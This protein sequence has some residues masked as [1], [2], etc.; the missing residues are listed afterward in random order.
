MFLYNLFRFI[1]EVVNIYSIALVIYALLSWFP[2]GYG[3]ALG[4]FLTRICE[5]YLSIFRKLPLQF[6]GLDFSIIV[7]LFGLQLLTRILNWLFMMIL[8]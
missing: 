5:P 4:R 3:S 8:Y 7:A 6:A 1:L 2:G